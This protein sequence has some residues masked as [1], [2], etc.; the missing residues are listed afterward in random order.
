MG[1]GGAGIDVGGKR[2]LVLA[3]KIEGLPFGILGDGADDA[4]LPRLSGGEQALVSGDGDMEGGS[5]LDQ[6]GLVDGDVGIDVIFKA[7]AVF[8]HDPDGLGVAGEVVVFAYGNV[9]AGDDAEAL[10]QGGV[11]GQVFFK[12]VGD[13]TGPQPGHGDGIGIEG[14]V[15]SVGEDGHVAAGNALVQLH[16][17]TDAG[18]A[19]FECA[20][21]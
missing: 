9:Q 18:V 21:L 17:D 1:E 13:I 12:A 11:E 7:L 4:G 6:L 3:F 16:P 2:D 8:V 5:A 10:L 19:F 20:V 14:S 15:G